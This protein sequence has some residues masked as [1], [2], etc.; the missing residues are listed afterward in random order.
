MKRSMNSIS[1]LVVMLSFLLTVS[2]CS[3][4]PSKGSKPKQQVIYKQSVTELPPDVL[5]IDCETI[6][7]DNFVELLLGGK[8]TVSDYEEALARSYGSLLDCNEDKQAL[9]YWKQL[10]E[11]QK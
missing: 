2:A 7:F 11:N 4:L 10:R 9:R 3:L 1:Y 6:F 8:A 5:L